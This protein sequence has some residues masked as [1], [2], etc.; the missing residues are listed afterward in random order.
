MTQ[1]SIAQYTGRYP[2]VDDPLIRAA[3]L[4]DV[5]VSERFYPPGTADWDQKA[6]QVV[7]NEETAEYLYSRFTPLTTSYET[8]SRPVLERILARIL[9]PGMGDREKLFAIL[10]YC[11]HDF[12]KE[13]PNILP[14]HTI[15]LNALE[16]ELLKFNGGHCEDRARLIIC[17]TQ[18][19]GLPSRFVASASYWDPLNDYTLVGGHAMVEICVDRRWAYFDSLR[20]FHCVLP[21]GRFASLW[22]IVSRPEIVETQPPAT[23]AACKATREWFI[24]YRD[25]NLS[26]KQI[27]TLTNYSVMDYKRYDWKWVCYRHGPGDSDGIEHAKFMKTLKEQLLAEL[28]VAATP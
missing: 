8:G 17:L 10:R 27:I 20:D 14:R 23:Y 22:D 9:A 24:K 12:Q 15:I 13:Y 19:A 5:K 11:L 2:R 25:E 26:R 3:Y 1:K 21:D 18:M 7:L 6:T 28:R 4:F 16:E